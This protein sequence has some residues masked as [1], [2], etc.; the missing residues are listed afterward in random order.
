MGVV[1][2][3]RPAGSHPLRGSASS[4]RIP[5]SPPAPPRR[6]FPLPIRLLL[7]FGSRTPLVP[8]SAFVAPGAALIG[9]AALGEDASI[10]F[11]AVLRADLNSIRV[12][13][14]SNLQDGVVVHVNAGDDSTTVAD[15]VTVGH[16]AVL[17]G[18]R[19]E[20]RCL[21]GMGSVVL[22][23]AVVGKEAMV[24]AGALVPPGLEIPPRMLARGV[25]A[26]IA[27]PLTDAEIAHLEWSAAHYVALKDRYLAEAEPDAA[28]GSPA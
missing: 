18:C 16:R 24:A 6:P 17:H 25:P 13:R 3:R 9:D 21:V 27:R 11:G 22:D 2:F 10:W 20:T 12:G 7:P 23:G 19:L 28:P 1:A 4:D 15:E 14:R 5:S 26:R 8:A